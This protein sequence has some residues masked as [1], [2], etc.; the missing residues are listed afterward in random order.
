METTPQLHQQLLEHLVKDL[1]VVQAQQHRQPHLAVLGGVVAV[2]L[3]IQIIVQDI[4]AQV[5]L[6]LYPQLQA[7][8]F[9]TLEAVAVRHMLLRLN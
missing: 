2:Q 5:V 4:L 6:E 8:K 3:E 9:F 7:H 1:R